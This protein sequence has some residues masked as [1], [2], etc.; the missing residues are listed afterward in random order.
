SKIDHIFIS[1]LHGDHYFGLVGL[2]SSLHLN[3]RIK[4]MK[5]FGPVA[6]LEILKIQFLHS[7]TVLRYPLE[8]TP[9]DPVSSAVILTNNDVVVESF[10]LNHRIPC[11]GYKFTEKL[12]GR[13]LITEKL[14]EDNVPLEYYQLLKRGV[15][16]NTPGGDKYLC[17]T[18]SLPPNAPRV[19]CYCSDTRYDASYFEY[20]RNADLLYH[21]ATFMHDLLERA[22]QTF[23]TTCIE[24][25]NVAIETGAKK[26]LIGH[27]SSR[28][29][30]LLPLL[31]EARSIFKETDIAVEG[32]TFTI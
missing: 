22:I 7:D 25:A 11:T 31:E 6:L 16:V 21:E 19:Y 14:E 28:Y 3:G 26:L 13:K 10:P 17:E 12:R 27:F 9:V 2:L 18:Y 4:P 8:F 20:V 29:K 24:A 32:R 15:D 30:S 1:H 5:I 23:H